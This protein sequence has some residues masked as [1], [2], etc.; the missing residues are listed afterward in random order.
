[1][2]DLGLFIVKVQAKTNNPTGDLE[3]PA[4]EVVKDA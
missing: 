3:A 1:V 4:L 2:S